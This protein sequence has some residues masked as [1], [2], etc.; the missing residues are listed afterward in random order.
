MKNLSKQMSFIVV[1]LA[2]T[3]IVGMMT[4]YADILPPSDPNWSWAEEETVVFQQ[5]LMSDDW[6]P[7]VPQ[8]EVY[9]TDRPVYPAVILPEPMP[10]FTDPTLS[11]WATKTVNI[12]VMREIVPIYLISN[13]NQHITRAELTDLVIT[14]Y[15]SFLGGIIG[16]DDVPALE[17]EIARRVP[18]FINTDNPN[19]MITTYLSFTTG[20]GNGCFDPNATLTREQA[21]IV[22]L[23]L[24]DII[25]EHPMTN[26]PPVI[27]DDAQYISVWAVEAV[28][29]MQAMGIMCSVE[30]NRFAP[31]ENFTREQSIVAMMRIFD[32]WHH[33][34]L[35]REFP[36]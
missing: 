23:H 36:L 15:S 3:L 9:R 34:M 13:F 30:G 7:G 33:E 25:L 5:D 19:V 12:A 17:R 35:M 6:P 28:E 21:A 31:Q 11:E 8:T 14:T 29:R 16:S 27:F 1:L 10:L 4:V 22:L 2:T 20:V 18:V 24:V 32:L 26:I